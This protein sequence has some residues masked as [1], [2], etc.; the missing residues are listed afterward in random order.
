MKYVSIIIIVLL[1][2]SCRSFSNKRT[3]INLSRVK[4]GNV[5]KY[6][7]VSVYDGLIVE[8]GDSIKLISNNQS[9]YDYYGVEKP[10]YKNDFRIITNDSIYD[11]DLKKVKFN[12]N[13]QISSQRYIIVITDTIWKGN[14]SDSSP[15][16]YNAQNIIAGK[17][18]SV[19]N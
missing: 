18:G 4:I 3:E 17:Y 8:T 12:I 2:L 9:F 10:V 15:V 5:D 14:E 16:F 13:K 19:P 1:A 7:Y 11:V 6:K